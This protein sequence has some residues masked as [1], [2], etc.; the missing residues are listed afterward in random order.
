MMHFFKRL[1]KSS[2]KDKASRRQQHPTNASAS[3]DSSQFQGHGNRG[4]AG[5]ENASY[6]YSSREQTS[7]AVK[8]PERVLISI[9]AFVCP[10]ATD[11]SYSSAE[12]TTI[13]AG[14]MLCDMRDLARLGLVCKAW[15]QAARKLQYRSI[16]LDSVHYCALEEELLAKRKRG[17]FFQK[18]TSPMAIPEQRMRLL[19]R[20]F[21]ESESIAESVFLLK[22]PYMT[23]ETC[24]QDLARLVSLLPNLRYVDLP[25]GVYQDDPSCASLKSILYTRCPDIRKMCWHAGSERN[26]ADLWAEPPWL[27]LEVVELSEMRVDNADL[28]QVLATLT[29]LRD[30]K[31]KFMPWTT[32][33]IFDCTST[34]GLFPAVK[35]LTLEEMPNISIDGL[36]TYLSRPEV[37]KNLEE[38]TLIRDANIQPHLLH[39]VVSLAPSL[40]SLKI[41][42]SVDQQIPRFGLPLISSRSLRELAYEI[43]DDEASKGLS[44]PSPSFYSYLS[45]SIWDNQL[46]ALKNLYVREHNFQERLKDDLASAG[47]F[48]LPGLTQKITVYSKG[49]EHLDW[50]EYIV[51][52]GQNPGEVLVKPIFRPERPRSLLLD[53]ENGRRNSGFS[54]GSA[55][56]GFLTVPGDGERSPGLSPSMMLNREARGSRQDLW[57]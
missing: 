49:A 42:A 11:E 8:V 33:A 35:H 5:H 44:K 30:L 19:Y 21:Q 57:R 32:D 6:S 28:V 29:T 48:A 36:T 38:L 1:L 7:P 54:V 14:C 41:Q 23:R 52:G 9:F 55:G 16:R 13:E 50:T 18:Q 4:R 39:A 40:K 37:Q 22:M 15:H 51:G 20:T 45:E 12:D 53:M 43:V 3:S 10:H 24:K 2:K 17:S 27:A 46:P 47:M 56:A 34:V 26:F 31:L 25:D